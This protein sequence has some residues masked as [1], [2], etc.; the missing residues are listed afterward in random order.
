MPIRLL[1][2]VAVELWL[3]PRRPP[4][5]A[6]CGPLAVGDVARPRLSPRLLQ[7]QRPPLSRPEQGPGGTVG[8]V[9]LGPAGCRAAACGQRWARGPRTVPCPNLT[10]VSAEQTCLSS[11]WEETTASREVSG[12]RPGGACLA[13]VSGGRVRHHCACRGGRALLSS[14]SFRRWSGGPALSGHRSLTTLPSPPLSQRAPVSAAS[15]PVWPA[16]F[17]AAWPARAPLLSQN[18]RV[19]G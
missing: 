17:A 8:R 9:A 1:L 4:G 11:V 16:V 5:F 13:G 14:S 3:E 10:V 18:W 12:L 19:Q 6:S 15:R 2:V 7:R